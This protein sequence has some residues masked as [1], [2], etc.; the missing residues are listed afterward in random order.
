MC[1]R[2]ESGY[3]GVGWRSGPVGHQDL[4]QAAAWGLLVSQ[5]R[6]PAR[7]ARRGRA[8]AGGGAGA[9]PYTRAVT[10]LGQSLRTT[11]SVFHPFFPPQVIVFTAS[12]GKYADPLLDLLD[13]SG[14][15]A[16]RLFREACFPFEGSY[17]KASVKCGGIGEG[18]EAG[19]MQLWV[20]LA[21]VRPGPGG[22]LRLLH[23]PLPACPCPP[24][25]PPQPRPAVLTP[26]HLPTPALSTT[27]R[28]RT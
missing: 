23:T 28:A 10:G 11:A 3:G 25:L 13:S 5:Q 16:W 18:G 14:T 19:R 27:P 20:Q 22:L 8:T 26:R 15:V 24:F 6:R 1:C 12:L 9:A 2:V 7:R 17:V 21:A 4:E